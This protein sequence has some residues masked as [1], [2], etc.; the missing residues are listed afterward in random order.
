MSI[1]PVSHG[2]GAGSS[3]DVDKRIRITQPP[4]LSFP[5]ALR[6]AT[7][8]YENGGGSADADLLNRILGN[9]TTSSSFQRKLQA[10]KAFRLISH[11]SPPVALTDVAEAIIAPKNAEEKARNLKGAAI[12]PL[13]F[14]NVYER[15]KGK[16]L[17]ADEYLRN[18]FLHD[19][20]I[21]KPVA[22]AWVIAF[23]AALESANLLLHRADGKIQ[24]LDSGSVVDESPASASQSEPV[25]VQD[26]ETP[27]SAIPEIREADR[28][29]D[30]GEGHTSRIAV[31]D[32]RYASI[33]IPDRLSSRDASRLKGALVGISAIIDSMVA[34]PND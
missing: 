20:A 10:L 19:L 18:G 3:V 16:L 17:P 25:A 23:K 30:S 22:E 21:P 6:I 28:G 29:H 31:S 24:V 12:G 32:G 13:P 5:E 1:K 15:F 9:S 14:R 2:D 26:S 33:Y 8:I 34:E 27:R 4:Y 7:A 11:L